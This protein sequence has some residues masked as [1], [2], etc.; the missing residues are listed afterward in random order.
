MQSDQEAKPQRLTEHL[1]SALRETTDNGGKLGRECLNNA[2]RETMH[3]A[4]QWD[5]HAESLSGSWTHYHNIIERDGG[6]G[7][8]TVIIIIIIIIM[9]IIII[10]LII[11][12]MY[13]N[14]N[15]NNNNSNMIMIIKN[16][17]NNKCY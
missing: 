1:N 15:N 10:I 12:T 8:R 9:I 13:Y 3:S 17:N 4:R 6:R 16:S 7:Q 14:N 11:K 5:N 2:L